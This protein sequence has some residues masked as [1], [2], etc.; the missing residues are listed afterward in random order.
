MPFKGDLNFVPLHEHVSCQLQTNELNIGV[1]AFYS[2]CIWLE[3]ER[4]RGKGGQMQSKLQ[5]KA[6]A[7]IAKI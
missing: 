7:C 1:G 6:S 3:G 2:L 5:L 4:V